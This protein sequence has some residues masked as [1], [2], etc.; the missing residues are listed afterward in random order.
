MFWVGGSDVLVGIM[1]G[2]EFGVFVFYVIMVV[3]F[4]VMVVEVYGE[5]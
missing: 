3:M 5:L 1:I 2:G 4:V